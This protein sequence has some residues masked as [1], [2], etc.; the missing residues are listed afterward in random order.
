MERHPN[1]CSSSVNARQT[2][3]PQDRCLG[4]PTPRICMEV[5]V[6]L[7]RGGWL[8]RTALFV[9][10]IVLVLGSM[11][12]VAEATTMVVVPFF[13]TTTEGNDNNGFP[14]NIGNSSMRYQ[15]VYGATDF[16]LGG[17]ATP[18]NITQIAFRPDASAGGAFS[19][20]L[21]SIQIDLSTTSKA[22]DGLSTTFADNVGAND[23]VVFPRGPLAL[24]SSN[25]GPAAGPKAFD[26]VV[27]LSTPFLYDPTKGN[28]LLDVRNFSGGTATFLDAQITQG[29]SI[30]RVLS[31][32]PGSTVS[33]STG[34]ADT[35]GLVTQFTFGAASV[36]P[37]PPTGTL[38]GMGAGMMFGYRSL[39][40]RRRRRGC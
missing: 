12:S 32:W 9:G 19:S 10:L 3:R 2:L 21:L 38:I 11:I 40:V 25:S 18:Q 20:T 24:S 16:V 39:L 33:S 28:L 6:N 8:M 14:F 22:P 4:R 1:P 13:D 31:D 5:P 36:V 7:P 35:I 29:D 15:Q 26:I 27:N 30:S 37:E 23:T 34:T 17:V